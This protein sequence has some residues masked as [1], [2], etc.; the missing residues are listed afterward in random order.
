MLFDLIHLE[1]PHNLAIGHV[2]DPIPMSRNAHE[3]FD[4]R[5]PGSKIGIADRPICC[6]PVVFRR[7]KFKVTPTL[8]L[9]GPKQRFSTELKSSDP[10]K[11]F[12]L[13]IFLIS[14]LDIKMPGGL[15]M[16]VMP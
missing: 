9:T 16:R 10:V 1:S 5:V 12:L 7:I 13:D 14:I 8:G 6:I 4:M 2:F 11:R 3:L 15:T